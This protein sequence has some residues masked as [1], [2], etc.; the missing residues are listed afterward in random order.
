MDKNVNRVKSYQSPPPPPPKPPPEE[1]PSPKPP[2]SPPPPLP[3]GAENV[4]EERLEVIELT[5]WE[6]PSGL[7][8]LNP[9]GETYQSGGSW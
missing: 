8:V 2:P 1:P 4:A 3:R 5:E 6:K 9:T 7:K